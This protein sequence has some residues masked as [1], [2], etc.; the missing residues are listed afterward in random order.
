MSDAPNRGQ[1]PRV[2]HLVIT[3]AHGGLERLV[4]DW[5]NARNQRHPGSTLIGCLDEPGELASQVAGGAVFGL[6]SR[7]GRFPWDREAAR[8]LIGRM[9][10]S[11]IRIVHSHNLAAQQYAVLAARGGQVG[12]VYTQHGANLHHWGWRDRLRARLL[13]ARTPRLVAV[14]NSTAEAMQRV[15]GVPAGRIQTIPNGTGPHPAYPRAA[16]LQLRAELGVP[17]GSR[18]IGSV[19][20]LAWIKGYDRLLTAFAAARR[21]AAEGDAPLTLLL[22]GDGPERAALEAQARGLGLGRSVVFAGYRAEPRM[23]LD[24]MGLFVLPSRSEGMPVS[25][26]EA[27]AAGVPALVTDVGSSREVID[28]GRA[29]QLLPDDERA[30]P[31]VLREALSGGPDE[32]ARRATARERVAGA[33]S[34]ERTLDAYERTYGAMLAT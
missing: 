8:R 9:A 33:F 1:A 34:I 29:G 3:L 32:E 19:G 23:A 24:L 6:G 26:L 30:W 7:R 13:N 10:E 31:A 15:F 28:D 5:T 2:L 11:G 17:D 12:H 16:V 18:V 25:L 4:V 21:G 20:R 27:M 14:S 22:V